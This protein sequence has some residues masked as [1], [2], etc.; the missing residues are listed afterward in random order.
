MGRKS[1]SSFS[2]VLGESVELVNGTIRK[3]DAQRVIQRKLKVTDRQAR[4]AVSSYRAEGWTLLPPREAASCNDA[5]A[6]VNSFTNRV[7]E[8][9]DNRQRFKVDNPRKK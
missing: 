9:V 4:A 7:L 3:R 5:L 8:H 1:G 6:D 2:D